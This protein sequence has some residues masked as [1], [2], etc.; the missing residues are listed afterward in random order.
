MDG[1]K[2]KIP[3]ICDN[4]LDRPF[5]TRILVGEKKK[6]RDRDPLCSVVPHLPVVGLW[7]GVAIGGTGS[8]FR[9]IFQLV[10][11]FFIQTCCAD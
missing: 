1:H 7:Y 4:L 3:T 8:L 6:I 2:G 9:C 5:L 10:C 11:Y